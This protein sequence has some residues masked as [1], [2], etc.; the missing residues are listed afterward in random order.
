MARQ[1]NERFL[2]QQFAPSEPDTSYRDVPPPSD[3]RIMPE[4]GGGFWP[5]IQWGGDPYTPNVP[6]RT[7]TPPNDR[8][9]VW[10]Q[11][12][13]GGLPMQNTPPMPPPEMMSPGSGTETAWGGMESPEEDPNF[14][15]YEVV[16]EVLPPPPTYSFLDQ[17][18]ASDALVAF[19]AAMLKAPDFNSGLGDAALAVNEVARSQRMPTEQDYAR[20]RQL[21][22]VK[23]IASGKSMDNNGSGQM[24]I[25]YSTAYSNDEGHT[26]FAARDPSGAQGMFNQNTGQFESGPIP[27]FEG[28]D[29][30][31]A[32]ANR[33][34]KLAIAD[35]QF[36]ADYA[37]NIPSHASNAFQFDQ[38]AK[39]ASEP[40]TAVDS[41]FLSRV[42]GELERLMPGYGLTEFDANNITEY[43]QRIQQAALSFARQ[44]FQGQGQ[45][46]EYERR[47]IFDSLGKRGTLT[48]ETAVKMLTAMRDIEQRK[49][50][51]FNAWQSNRELKDRFQYNFGAFVGWYMNEEN[52]RQMGM[53]GNSNTSGGSGQRRPLD[54]IFGN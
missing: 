14:D 27:G 9:P 8:G 7:M 50:D 6:P 40:S 47:M 12:G 31:S 16:N 49:I 13:R 39:L 10:E 26:L 34:K 15:P 3:M 37:K 30:Y 35:G 1:T 20:A 2:R 25:D 44:S 23:R 53:E 43:D 22:I 36:E 46:T 4:Q 18:G 19:G 33:S 11:K 45:V 21:G 48:K 38:L 41:S 32:Y 54:A 42:G 24:E 17:P 52:K 51:M 29:S 28:R 5:N